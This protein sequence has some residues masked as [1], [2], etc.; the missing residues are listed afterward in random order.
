MSKSYQ[1]TAYLH[2]EAKEQLQALAAENRVS[3]SEQLTLLVMAERQRVAP[4]TWPDAEALSALHHIAIGVDA[5][6]KFHPDP[7]AV[8]VAKEAR[9]RRLKFNSDAR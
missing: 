6:L 1:V 2:R 5:L 4:T 8:D 7:R 3:L 9:Q